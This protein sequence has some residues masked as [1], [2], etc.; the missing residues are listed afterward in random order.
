MKYI[1][2]LF[3][4][5]PFICWTL[6]KIYVDQREEESWL[7]MKSKPEFYYCGIFKKVSSYDTENISYTP[8]GLWNQ[9]SQVLLFLLFCPMQSQVHSCRSCHQAYWKS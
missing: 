9:N 6:K 4:K 5:V 8:M 7:C 3:L 2:M 1:H